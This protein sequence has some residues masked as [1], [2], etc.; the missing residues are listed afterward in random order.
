MLRIWY[1]LSKVIFP[2]VDAIK[3][4]QKLQKVISSQSGNAARISKTL[5]I[6]KG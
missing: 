3:N 4:R 6:L 1:M 5:E 2:I